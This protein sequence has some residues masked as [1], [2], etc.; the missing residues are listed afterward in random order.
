MRFAVKLSPGIT[1]AHRSTFTFFPPFFSLFLFFF[2]FITKRPP[3][4]L[5]LKFLRA[6]RAHTS[7]RQSLRHMDPLKRDDETKRAADRGERV[8]RDRNRGEGRGEGGRSRSQWNKMKGWNE[9]TEVVAYVI[10]RGSLREG[11][12]SHVADVARYQNKWDSRNR[13]VGTR[14][15]VTP[16]CARA[17]A[18]A[19]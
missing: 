2:F 13:L 5:S 1:G 18:H 19:G 17:R 9:S 16:E 4:F 14:H 12:W 3:A 7:T 8:V 6:T 10:S 11:R 15:A